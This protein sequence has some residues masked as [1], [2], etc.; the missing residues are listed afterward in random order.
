MMHYFGNSRVRIFTTSNK[1]VLGLL[2]GIVL[3]S[4][5]PFGQTNERIG[6]D[7]QALIQMSK[8]SAKSPTGAKVLRR[9]TLATLNEKQLSTMVTYV[10]VRIDDMKAV[11]DYSQI[12]LSYNNYQESLSLDFANVIDKDGNAQPLA[13]DAIQYQTPN[14]NDFY[15]D[16]KVLIFSL[17]NVAIGSILEFQYTAKD[18]NHTIEGE[19]FN[20]FSFYRWQK[21]ANKMEYRADPIDHVS[22]ALETPKGTALTV[23]N[24]TGINLDYKVK[25]SATHKKYFWSVRDMHEFSMENNMPISAGVTPRV[26]LSTLKS[27]DQVRAWVANTFHPKIILDKDIRDIALQIAATAPT[28][29][30]KLK[31]VYEFMQKN[32][33]YVFAHVGRGGYTPHAADDVLRK[34]YGDCKDQAVL[35][36][37]ILKALGIEAKPALVS[38]RSNGFID[39]SIPSTAFDHMIT[40]IPAAGGE[41][42][43]WMDTSIDFGLYPGAHVGIENRPALIIDDNVGR[44]REVPASDSR[45]EALLALNYEYRNDGAIDVLFRISLTGSYEQHLR[46]WWKY[47]P[48]RDKELEKFVTQIYPGSKVIEANVHNADNLWAPFEIDGRIRISDAWKGEQEAVHI[49]TS[50][51]QLARL[52]GGYDNLDKPQNRRQPFEISI[53]HQLTLSATIKKPAPNYKILAVSSGTNLK[54]EFF[55]LIQS[56][57]EDDEA[58]HVNIKF[59]ANKAMMDAQSYAIFFRDIET[60]QSLPSWHLSYVWDEKSEK[61]AQIKAANPDQGTSQSHTAM[62]QF[63]LDNGEFA[64]AL[65]AASSAIALSPDNGLA[66]Y[67]LGMAQGYQNMFDES[68]KSFAKARALGHK[69]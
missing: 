4:L 35:T 53:A 9:K 20:I 2:L 24:P 14:Q 29:E 15:Q 44:I 68:A 37:S 30:E 55:E 6:P 41:P 17:P 13:D 46:G 60:M 27:W 57:T 45:H 51:A 62:A 61:I 36:V 65:K 64:K 34:G 52:F 33:R 19:W 1:T 38:T 10:A 39:M 47:A 28:R 22:Y 63:H 54:T 3:L 12:H 11:R 8:Q 32:V 18:I 43:I 66:F 16:K 25:Q 56:G 7:Q 23:I 48:Q 31:K 42:A 58:Y 40:Y 67:L 59:S 49:A 21:D 5:S 50:I 69:R 26:Y